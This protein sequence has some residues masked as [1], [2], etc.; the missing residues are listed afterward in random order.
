MS[1]CG[2]RWVPL[3]WVSAVPGFGCRFRPP[4]QACFLPFFSGS[5]SV[6]RS[7]CSFRSCYNANVSVLDIV[8]Q[9]IQRSLVFWILFLLSW[10]RWVDFC[11]CV[12]WVCDSFLCIIYSVGSL[13]CGFQLS[14]RVRSADLVFCLFVEFLTKFIHSPPGFIEHFCNHYFELYLLDCLSPFR[15][16]H[17][18]GFCPVLFWNILPLPPL[19]AY[20]S[21]F[22]S[23]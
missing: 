14:D 1:R 9:I 23:V 17:F 3:V 16:A 7:L 19:V 21:V 13:Q 2:P 20:L 4:G 22:L 5:L 8:P 15:L 10:F 18:L 12:F 6:P 11:C